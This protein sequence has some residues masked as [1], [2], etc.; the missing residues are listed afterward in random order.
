MTK[1]TAEFGKKTERRFLDCCAEL[2]AA[3][4]YPAWLYFF[5]PATEKEDKQGVDLW[6][7][8]DAGKI[9]VQIKSGLGG[10]NRHMSR[11]NRRH[12]PC[13][14][15]SPSRA[16]EDIFPEAIELLSREHDRILAEQGQEPQRAA[17][18]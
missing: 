17:Q 5:E 7:Y 9:P 16:F 10:F 13:I 8:T 2:R 4:R 18:G 1:D 12:I 15:V 6:A 14:V 3:G 11:E